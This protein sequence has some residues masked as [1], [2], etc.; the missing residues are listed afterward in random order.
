MMAD[1]SNGVL[2]GRDSQGTKTT[3]DHIGELKKIHQEKVSYRRT[4][5]QCDSNYINSQIG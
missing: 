5:T 3:P 4:C 2:F 1:S